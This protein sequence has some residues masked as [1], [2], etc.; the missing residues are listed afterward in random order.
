MTLLQLEY[1]LEVNKTGSFSRAAQTLYVSQ[2]SI[3]RAICALE[4][5]LGV[6]IFH[7]EWNGVTPTE[8]GLVVLEQAIRIR[9]SYQRMTKQLHP[10]RREVRL[11]FLGWPPLQN[12]FLRLMEEY[13]DDS[14]VRLVQRHLET[15]Q[16]TDALL[17]QE[18]DL[19]LSTPMLSNSRD[20]IHYA[21]RTGV[22]CQLL[23]S[24][25]NSIFIAPAHPLYH[26]EHLTA[27]DFYNDAFI[28]RGKLARST[29]VK[30]LIN[31]DT[32]KAI[33]VDNETIRKKL[34]DRGYGYTIAYTRTKPPDEND[35]LR[36]IPTD[37]KYALISVTN[38]ARPQ[39]PVVLRFLELVQEEMAKVLPYLESKSGDVSE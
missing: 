23:G 6:T 15:E 24:I 29:A 20:W 28:D 1:I 22:S 18:I 34:R 13:R 25:P 21:E 9:E 12:A 30:P 5:E 4:K 31:V 17:L 2:A 11:A 19:A 37:L 36:E 7:R 35:R 3:S 8:Q 10:A 38:P 39:D 27:Q 16:L 33:L 14:S 26:K 32:S